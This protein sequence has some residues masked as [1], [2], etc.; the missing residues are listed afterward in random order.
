MSRFYASVEGQAQTPAT[1]RGSPNSGIRGH[2]RGWDVG[3][4]V[5]C[6]VDSEGKDVCTVWATG[7]SNGHRNDLLIAMVKR[8]GDGE[9]DIDTSYV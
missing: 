7:G 1:R 9:L 3:I 4:S 5:A 2:L 8:D 6:E